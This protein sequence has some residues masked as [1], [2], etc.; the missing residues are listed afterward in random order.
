M[1]LSSGLGCVSFE[2]CRLPFTTRALFLNKGCNKECNRGA[3]RG[4]SKGCNMGVQTYRAC[5][6]VIRCMPYKS[7]RIEPP[8]HEAGGR[9]GPPRYRGSR[10]TPRRPPACMCV[11]PG[12]TKTPRRRATRGRVG[13]PRYIGIRAIG[14]A[15]ARHHRSAQT[16]RACVHHFAPIRADL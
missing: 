7:A 2:R 13:A 4:A 6:R 5:A 14:H 10:A 9:G 8:H 3:A 16:Y 12:L 15:C 1:F 11:G